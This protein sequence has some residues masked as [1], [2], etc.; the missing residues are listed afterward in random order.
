GVARVAVVSSDPDN[1]VL[2]KELPSEIQVVHRDQLERVQ[3]ALRE[4]QGV[5]VLIYDQTCAAEL[6]RR[7]KR[8]TAPEPDRRVI[9]NDR[10]CE[11]CGDCSSEA[12]CVS[13]LPLDTPLGRKRR[14]D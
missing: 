1:Q 3:R 2:K 13:I 5:T 7:R 11:G 8:K 4:E 10:V 6:R 9:I 14:I 12:N